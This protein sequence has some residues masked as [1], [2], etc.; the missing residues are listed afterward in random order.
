MAV[1]SWLCKLTIDQILVLDTSDA[2]IIIHQAN[3]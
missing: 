3:V 2:E 1:L